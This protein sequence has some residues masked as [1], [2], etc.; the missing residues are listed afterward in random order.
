[1]ITTDAR[2]LP[3]GT[4]SLTIEAG[5]SSIETTVDIPAIA[6]E[7]LVQASTNVWE[8]EVTLQIMPEIQQSPIVRVEYLLNNTVLGEATNADDN[9]AY[10]FLATERS[11][12]A[13]FPPGQHTLTA[14]AFDDRGQQSRSKQELTVVVAEPP[15]DPLSVVSEYWWAL[16][17]AVVLIISLIGFSFYQR[18]TASGTNRTSTDTFK[19]RQGKVSQP[20]RSTSDEE[21]TKRYDRAT[22]AAAPVG[23]QTHLTLPLD[24]DAT[25]RLNKDALRTQVLADE[26][27][28][29][30]RYSATQSDLYQLRWRV[31]ILEGAEPMTLDLPTSQR[32][33][34]IGRPSRGQVQPHIAIDNKM[35]SRA[36][37]TLQ[38]LRD[39]LELTVLETE[40]GTF[41][42]EERRPVEPKDSPISL[43]S[44]DVFWL[45]PR[46][47]VRVESEKYHHGR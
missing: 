42:G 22:P 34:D 19:S 10:T 9:F 20:V 27:E 4:N 6:P 33:F 37:A 21:I 11:F 44:G 39:G 18:N 31:I 1:V 41:V 40:N 26:D 29:T 12:L 8:N 36:H 17:G 5:G 2:I 15:F 38:V 32:H 24:D 47:K 43:A 45:S 46:V 23:A 7:F 30:T 14:A 3:A 25:A 13:L 28:K 16:A 35:V